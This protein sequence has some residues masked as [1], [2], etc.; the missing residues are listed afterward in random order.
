[1]VYPPKTEPISLAPG[2]DPEGISSTPG[3]LGMNQQS[4]ASG[5]TASCFIIKVNNKTP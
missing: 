3:G 5:P 4:N 2:T 1:M